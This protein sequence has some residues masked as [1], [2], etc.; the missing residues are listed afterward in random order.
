[1]ST[2]HRIVLLVIAAVLC[3]GLID[4]SGPALGSLPGMFGLALGGA[5]WLIAWTVRGILWCIARAHQRPERASGAGLLAEVGLVLVAA[6]LMWMQTP[7]RVRF[8]LSEPAL[9]RYAESVHRDPKALEPQPTHLGLFPVRAIRRGANSVVVVVE[10]G[11]MDL[12]GFVYTPDGA[13]EE[14][15][16]QQMNAHWYRWIEGW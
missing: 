16:A 15:S 12:N 8:A 7:L 14:K 11:F 3:A 9:T 4:Q 10:P 6:A 13:P 2:R 1:M 5:V